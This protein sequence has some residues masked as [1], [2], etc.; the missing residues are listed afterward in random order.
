MKRSEKKAVWI[1]ICIFSK[2]YE[3]IADD[4]EKLVCYSLDY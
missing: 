1:I 3:R 2:F 4:V